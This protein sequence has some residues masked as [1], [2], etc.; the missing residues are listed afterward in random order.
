MD[1]ELFNIKEK[2]ILDNEYKNWMKKISNIENEFAVS[3]NFNNKVALDHGIEHMNRVANNVYKLLEEYNCKK[4]ICILGYIAGLIHDIGMIYGKKGHAKNGAEMSK[5]FLKKLDFIDTRDI[6]KITNA[7]KNHGNGG[8][9]A[10]EITSFLTI[11]DKVDICKSRFLGNVSPIQHIENYTIN[12]KDGILQINYA[13]TD[14]KGKEALYTIPKSIDIPKT[15]GSNLGLK[16][17][18]YINEKYEQFKDREEYK[19]Q[20]Y[21]RK[22]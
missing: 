15:L 6:E 19:G 2:I 4:N 20:I 10:D 18:F 7:I 13:M 8:T 21:Q 17:E 14:L 22:E 9:N 3:S 11:S 5:S 12:I 16:V 1:N